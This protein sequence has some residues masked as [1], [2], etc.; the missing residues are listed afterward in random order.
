MNSIFNVGR[1]LQVPQDGPV[2]EDCQGALP[3]RQ[4]PLGQ[5]AQAQ[6]EAHRPVANR[7]HCLRVVG[8]AAGGD[9]FVR[10]NQ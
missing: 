10:V 9:N 7:Q 5:E 1:R 2:Q 4:D 6:D 3:Q 8:D